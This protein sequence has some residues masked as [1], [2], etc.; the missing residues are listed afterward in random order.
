MMVAMS[1]IERP[2]NQLGKTRR[3]AVISAHYRE[4]GAWR[5][6]RM[7]SRQQ[8]PD[9][10]EVTPPAG[11]GTPT[12]GLL[13]HL[14]QQGGYAGLRQG[15]LVQCIEPQAAFHGKRNKSHDL[16]GI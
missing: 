2:E 5:K 14:D 13:C 9:R 1:L 15:E 10:G 3:S 12:R 11:A 8:T 6:P 4:S 16:A 7:R